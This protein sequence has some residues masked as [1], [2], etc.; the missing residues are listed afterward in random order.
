MKKA[1][2]LHVALLRSINVGGKNKLAMKDLVAMFDDVGCRHIQTYIQSGNV[3]FEANDSLAKRIPLLI[4]DAIEDRFGYRV[5]LV[6]RTA[7]ELHD[8]VNRNPFL[9]AGIETKTLHVAFLS[10]QSQDANVASLDPDRSPPDEFVVCGREIYLHCPKGYARTKLTTS[11][12][13]SRLGT[14]T[15]VRN[16]RTVLKVIE[17]VGG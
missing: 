4:S 17:M 11:Y 7:A 9:K 15:T 3:V 16:W 13:D 2:A 6:L 12:F 1:V 14:T 10:D 5:P 8:V